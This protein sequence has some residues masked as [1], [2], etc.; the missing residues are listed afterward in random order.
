[1]Y[2]KDFYFVSVIGVV[3]YNIFILHNVDKICSL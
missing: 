1:M 2:D 3:L